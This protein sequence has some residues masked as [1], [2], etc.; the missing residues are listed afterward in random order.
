MLR[1][2]FF[3]QVSQIRG[4]CY[5]IICNEQISGEMSIDNA[6]C[7]DGGDGNETEVLGLGVG[8]VLAN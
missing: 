3:C 7:L 4:P 6:Y 8:L 5:V 1:D 2:V